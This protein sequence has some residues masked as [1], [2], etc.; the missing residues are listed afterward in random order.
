MPPVISSEAVV[1]ARTDHAPKRVSARTPMGPEPTLPLDEADEE[2]EEDEDEEEEQRQ[3]QQQQREDHDKHEEDDTDAE[4]Q[5]DAVL[6][7]LISG[8]VSVRH[9]VSTATR[10]RI[11]PYL[12]CLGVAEHTDSPR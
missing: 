3:Q 8:S 4:E 12:W 9:Y 7:D 1:A 5:K 11:L 10:V 6:D 2:E